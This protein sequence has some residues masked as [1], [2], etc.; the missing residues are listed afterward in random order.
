MAA[1]VTFEGIRSL[2]DGEEP[3]TSGVA[4][5]LLAASIV[6]MPLLARAKRPRR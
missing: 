4:L 2:V 1:Y 3:D 6:V 5:V